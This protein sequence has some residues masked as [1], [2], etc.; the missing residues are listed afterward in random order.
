[1]LSKE[2]I[3]EFKVLYKKHYKQD[4]FDQKTSRRANKLVNPYEVIYTQVAPS[5][6]TEQRVNNAFDILFNEVEKTRK[7]NEK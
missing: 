3:E 5:E 1:M 6:E 2:A 4:I 7:K